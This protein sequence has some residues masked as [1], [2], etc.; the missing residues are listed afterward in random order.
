MKIFN[1]KLAL[2]ATII[3]FWMDV[4]G[5]RA[6]PPE[7]H[8]QT[9]YNT[10]YVHLYYLQD[11]SYRPALAAETIPPEVDSLTA[12]RRA[13]QIKQVLDGRGLYVRLHRVPRDSTYRDSITRGHFYVPFPNR[14]PDI[15]LERIDGK[16]YYSP[17]TIQMVPTIHSKLFPLGADILE[18]ILPRS[19]S[20]RFLGLELWQ[21]LGLLIVVGVC[22]L[23]HL[24]V[25]RLLRPLV[26]I[27]AS[28]RLTIQIVS[29]ETI[30]KIARY[31]SVILI[32]W[33]ARLFLPSVQLP[34][35]ASE[36]A[37]KSL[38]I[39]TVIILILLGFAIVNIFIE[40]GRELASRTESRMDDQV[41]PVLS[42]ILKIVVVLI[43]IFYILRLLSVNVTALIAGLSIGGLAL[44]LAAQ[45]TIK[46]FIGSMSIFTDKPFQVG[47]YVIANGLEGTVVEVGFRSTRIMKID[48]SIV[49]IPNGTIANMSL[50]NLDVRTFRMLNWTIGVTYQTPAA[51]IEEFIAALRELVLEHPRIQNE[52][53]LVYFREMSASSLD[54][55]M[56][57]YLDAADF[58]E[59][60]A[61]KEE[62]LL[63]IVRLA[64]SIGVDFAYPTQTL[65]IESLPVTE[66]GAPQVMK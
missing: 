53:Y 50:E 61:L 6:D 34:I 43:G 7:V 8:L 38:S 1:V 15:F 39:L 47:D 46:N 32:I 17:E 45:D 62:I 20:F 31:A 4:S 49:T 40:R 11:D 41:I 13:I 57:C 21:Y 60:L 56:R 24:I 19:I 58:N 65:H 54:I 25:S 10:M 63:K 48:T 35:R 26:R 30:W 51:K 66:P 64:E 22:F 14:L 36:F 33:F 16:W 37:H 2:L 12:V 28:Q 29:K 59:E 42:R 52:P 23:L 44:A 55:L 27:L 18:N 5:Q 9:P 3:A